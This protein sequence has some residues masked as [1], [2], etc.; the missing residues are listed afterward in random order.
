MR[1][2]PCSPEESL[3]VV[4]VAGVVG[5]VDA[6]YNVVDETIC[7]E[8]DGNEQDGSALAAA[9]ALPPTR[10][11]PVRAK[12]RGSLAAHAR[13]LQ[14]LFRGFRRQRSSAWSR[15]GGLAGLVV[16]RPVTMF[17]C[18]GGMCLASEEE[19]EA[20][21]QRG[22]EVIEHYS[23]YVDLLS[24]LKN[25]RARS[26]HPFAAAGADAEGVRRSRGVPFGSVHLDQPEFR[27]HFGD[28]AFKVGD[29]SQ[30]ATLE[31]VVRS[32]APDVI[33]ASP[34]VPAV[35]YCRHARG[36]QGQADDSFDAWLP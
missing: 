30:R 20:Q 33:L 4:V 14:H 9:S 13:F 22:L 11:P 17:R 16:S 31:S 19:F 26:Y 6:G 3:S 5:A 15:R 25:R 36:H 12:Q 29:A 10:A 32:W 18:R 7:H 35:F 27:A 2:A 24:R 28:R 23:I 1:E 21:R 8:C 34:P